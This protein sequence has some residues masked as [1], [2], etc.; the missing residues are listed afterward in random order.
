MLYYRILPSGLNLKPLT[1]RSNFKIPNFTQVL[2]NIK[3]KKTLGYVL[4]SVV[5]PDFKTLEILEILPAVLTP[6]QIS[7]LKFISHYYVVNLSVAAGL[8]TPL[9]IG[10]P[11]SPFFGNLAD[12]LALCDKNELNVNL[13]LNAKFDDSAELNSATEFDEISQSNLPQNLNNGGYRENSIRDISMPNFD[14]LADLFDISQNKAT[15][16]KVLKKNLNLKDSAVYTASNSDNLAYEK[17]IYRK[18]KFGR[19]F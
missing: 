6:I 15:A 9:E 1:Y 8:F 7:L 19:C 16:R 11:L 14:F 3:N 2:V 17:K 4:Q 13:N 12:K 5:E 18:A 10:A